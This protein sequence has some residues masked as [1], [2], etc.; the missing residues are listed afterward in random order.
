MPDLEVRAP[1]GRGQTRPGGQLAGVGE[2][3]DVA[4]LGHHDQRGELPDAGQRPQCL[5]PQVGLGV[6]VQFAVE[7]A[8]QY[9]QGGR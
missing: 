3:G 1:H 4:D 5:D 8:G 2:P 6:L 9:C 7:P